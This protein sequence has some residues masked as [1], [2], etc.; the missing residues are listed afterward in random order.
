[1]PGSPSKVPSL[2]LITS[3]ASGSLLQSAPPQFEQKHLRKPV[4][5]A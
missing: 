2:T 5:G 3:P 4:G 1:M